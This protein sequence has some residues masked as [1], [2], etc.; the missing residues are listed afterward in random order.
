MPLRLGALTFPVPLEIINLR[1]GN[2]DVSMVYLLLTICSFQD[3]ASSTYV[4]SF[5]IK[6][7]P[8]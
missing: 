8:H 6:Q 5:Y 2:E 1:T 7:G 4:E 3:Q